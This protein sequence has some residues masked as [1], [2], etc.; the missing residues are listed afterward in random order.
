MS[1]IKIKNERWIKKSS[2]SL[3]W[4]VYN[5]LMMSNYSFWGSDRSFLTTI[6]L[7]TQKG[8]MSNPVNGPPY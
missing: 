2:N 4:S 1:K 5:I 8:F 6:H 3:A 7:W